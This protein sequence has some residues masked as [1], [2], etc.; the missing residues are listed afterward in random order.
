MRHQEARR[1][2]VL[3]RLV[4]GELTSTQAAELLG[5]SQRQVKRLKQAF[6]KEG[7]GEC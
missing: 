4:A 7:L 6:K 1:V 2:Y 5:L 3:E